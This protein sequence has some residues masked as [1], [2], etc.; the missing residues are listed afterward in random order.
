MK[1]TDAELK[2][3]KLLHDAGERVKQDLEYFKQEQAALYKANPGDFEG[4]GLDDILTQYAE[5]DFSFL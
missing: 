2:F 3:S 4:C 5:R 1:M